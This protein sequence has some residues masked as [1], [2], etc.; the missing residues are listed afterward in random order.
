MEGIRKIFPVLLAAMLV[1]AQRA[2][3]QEL[4]GGQDARAQGSQAQVEAPVQN[5]VS[6]DSQEEEPEESGYAFPVIPPKYKFHAGYRFAGNSGSARGADEYDFLHN[7]VVFGGDARL[8]DYP[9]RFHL[10]IDEVNRNDYYGYLNYSYKDLVYFEGDTRA[11]FHNL[12][13]INLILLT[14]APSSVGVDNRAPG[15]SFG[16]KAGMDDFVFRLKAPGYP[17][18]L[19]VKGSVF[20]RDGLMEQRFLGGAGFFNDAVRTSEARDIDYTT[21]AFQAGI[22]G[23]L[24]PLEAQYE[25]EEKRFNANGQPVL[26]DNF[27]AAGF[28]PGSTLKAG[29]YP[30]NEFSQ[31]KGSSNM[32]MLHTSY[33]GEIVASATIWSV[34]RKN[35]ESG[36]KA[37]YIFGEGEV[38]WTPAPSTALFF[39]YRHRQVDEDT[40]SAI[41]FDNVCSPS[42]NTAGTYTC[43]LKPAISSNTD[44]ASATARYYL[45]P[46]AVISAR[47]SYDNIR[48]DNATVWNLPQSTQKDTE[49]IA[50]DINAARDLDIKLKYTHRNIFHPSVNS[51][52]NRADE[53]RISA[54]WLPASWIDALVYYQIGQEHRDTLEFATEQ[55]VPVTAPG[56][57]DV[58]RDKLLADITFLVKRNLTV[59]TIYSYMRDKIQEPLAYNNVSGTVLFD[60]DVPAGQQVNYYAVN[61]MYSP[62]DMLTFNAGIGHT[63]AGIGF[64]PNA[65]NITQPVPISSF[66]TLD[67]HETDYTISGDYRFKRG[68]SGS[69]SYRY[70]DFTNEGGNPY[71]EFQNG[72]AHIIL[73]S[74]TRRW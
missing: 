31:L 42:N 52:P 26:F 21:E 11:V 5:A 41:T 28:P 59:S 30:H 53:G 9:N 44:S 70:S 65:P 29:I 72:T 34:D 58:R 48:R 61:A 51:E 56:G 33:T 32:L 7:S 1:F 69:L 8:F 37:D 68:M 38:T 10:I 43:S 13:N 67:M 74:L 20:N 46:G 62:F 47:Y 55:F 4:A 12:G 23:H 17:A 63:V 22:N 54:S 19:Y 14:P 45:L 66:S 36:A 6:E 50:M 2:V 3:C 73:V 39:K 49:W 64:T 16:Y 25:H 35:E 40:P 18:H 27:A 24:G 60:P 57:R 71:T 15:A